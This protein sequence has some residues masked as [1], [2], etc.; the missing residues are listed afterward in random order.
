MADACATSDGLG[1]V[2]PCANAL[3][4]AAATAYANVAAVPAAAEAG[5]TPAAMTSNRSAA[6][7][8]KPR[9]TASFSASTAVT[10]NT[11][12]DKFACTG[13]VSEVFISPVKSP[14]C[15]LFSNDAF[16]LLF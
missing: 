14:W 1:A 11:R 8:P 7:S 12:C 9:R 5:P 15:P 6:M 4:L 10:I 2:E 3:V 13:L 16:G